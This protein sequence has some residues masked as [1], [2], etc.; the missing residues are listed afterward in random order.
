MDSDPNSSASI[1][2]DFAGLVG[3]EW[4]MLFLLAALMI[5]SGIAAATE[6]AFFSLSP[7]EVKEFKNQNGMVWRLLQKPQRLLATI[8]IFGNFVNIA[9]IFMTMVGTQRVFEISAWADAQWLPWVK[10]PLAIAIAAFLILFFGEITP[11]IY[12]SQNRLQ[13]V[14]LLGLPVSVMHHVLFPISYILV[15]TTQFWERRI[16]TGSIAAS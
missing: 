4:P 1:A 11:K 12:A 7:I 6:V 16:K 8:L 13:L 14:R 15:S 5:C 3:Q 2:T 10:Y 9:I